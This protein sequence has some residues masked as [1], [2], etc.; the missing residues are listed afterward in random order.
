MTHYKDPKVS[1]DLVRRAMQALGAGDQE[2]SYRQVYEAIGLSSEGQQAVVRS[3]IS[4]MLRHG[5]VVR[6]KAGIFTYNA[7]YR[8]REGK[9]YITIWRFVRMAKSGWDIK[10]CAMLTR[11]SY[12]QVLRYIT[13]L[14]GE[15][16]VERTGRNEAR[17]IVYR[18][19]AKA[20]SSPE[21]PYPP[22]KETDPF[23]KERVAAAT[24]TRLMLCADTYAPKTARD[25]V[26][27]CR[28]LLARF[29]KG[30]AQSVTTNENEEKVA[31]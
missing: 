3:R 11:I 7:K 22:Q 5:E 6:V 30:G 28:V 13:W 21:T 8:P 16:F 4:D 1:K 25:I 15:A 26:E 20:A 29:K 12:T 17:G 18:A 31:C 2:V 19:T 9:T 24:I 23:H 27:A 14:E 10:E